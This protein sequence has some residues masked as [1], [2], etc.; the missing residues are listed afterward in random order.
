P[1]EI[2]AESDETA[3]TLHKGLDGLAHVPRPVL[4]VA[5]GHE[6]GI[7]FEYL[8]PVMQVGLRYNVELVAFAFGPYGEMT[9]ELRPARGGIVLAPAAG[10]APFLRRVARRIVHVR[11]PVD[12]NSCRTLRQPDHAPG[13]GT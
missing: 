7:V 13:P 11:K 9:I 1:K 6:T 10:I 4:V 8:R 12:R 3:A 5:H 2:A